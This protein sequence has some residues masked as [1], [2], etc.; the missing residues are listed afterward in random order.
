[1][2]LSR[3][4]VGLAGWLERLAPVDL[5]FAMVTIVGG[6]NVPGVSQDFKNAI[7]EINFLDV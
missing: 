4:A 3:E 5:N 6:D 2:A 7:R 1:M